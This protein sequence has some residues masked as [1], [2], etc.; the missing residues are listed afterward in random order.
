[1]IISIY[2]C[3]LC[4]T[5]YREAKEI[6][7]AKNGLCMDIKGLLKMRFKVNEVC[8]SCFESVRIGI[9]TVIQEATK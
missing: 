8:I 7:E 1:M 2:K 6:Y 3:D 5:E 9:Q 4:K